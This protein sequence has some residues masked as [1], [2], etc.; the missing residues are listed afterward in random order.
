MK[1]IHLVDLQTEINFKTNLKFPTPPIK[2][3]KFGKF[4]R[5]MEKMDSD[6]LYGPNFGKFRNKSFSQPGRTMKI[7]MTPNLNRDELL[8][9]GGPSSFVEKDQK[10][11]RQIKY[12][13]GWLFTRKME[14][15]LFQEIP[16]RDL[17]I[18]GMY[19]DLPKQYENSRV[20]FL[21]NG[22][23]ARQRSRAKSLVE[24]KKF[25]APNMGTPM[26]LSYSVV[27]TEECSGMS[28]F[29]KS[30]Y[31]LDED[32][33]RSTFQINE[34]ALHKEHP[35]Q[36]IRFP[37]IIKKK[38]KR[39]Q[40]DLDMY[41]R[42][43]DIQDNI[44]GKTQTGGTLARNFGN[45][46]I[47]KWNPTKKINMYNNFFNI[48]RKEGYM[49]VAGGTNGVV[50]DTRSNLCGGM[51]IGS[52]GNKTGGTRQTDLLSRKRYNVI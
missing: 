9:L 41:D 40:K 37:N 23:T 16:K 31:P 47:G 3:F 45:F 8:N 2:K 14:K 43:N 34:N 28:L 30:G 26:K 22:V 38:K 17:N 12:K 51:T 35:V 39:E 10:V 7:N 13:V 20:E 50:L 1:S 33:C 42:L 11:L 27:S 36:K 44:M 15:K 46:E 4:Y 32:Y 18:E 6:L 52:S 49:Y 5:L 25:W 48:K 21:G 19:P 29:D 24:S